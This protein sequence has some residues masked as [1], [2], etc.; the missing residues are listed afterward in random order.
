[1]VRRRRA[2]EPLGQR[3]M[4]PLGGREEVGRDV[5]PGNL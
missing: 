4:G 2:G 1:M 3:I 5:S